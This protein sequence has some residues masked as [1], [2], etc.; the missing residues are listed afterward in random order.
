[1]PQAKGLL[2]EFFEDGRRWTRGRYHDG[3]GSHC[4][5]GAIWY[6]ARKHKTRSAVAVSFLQEVLPRGHRHL[7]YF[8]DMSGSFAEVRA[9][10]VK[11]R[12]AVVAEAKE[13]VKRETTAENAKRWLL[14]EIERERAARVAAGDHW[15]TYILCPRVP[16]PE[17][18]AA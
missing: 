6:L 18:L 10:I 5:V 12:S 4:L 11:T 7:V 8:N 17:R 2:L 1:M 3:N 16:V 13:R 14:A 9:L 15:A